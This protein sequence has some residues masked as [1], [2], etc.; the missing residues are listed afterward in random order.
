MKELTDVQKA[1]KPK[2]SLT[3]SIVKID[4]SVSFQDILDEQ[5][6]E[7]ISYEEFRRLADQIEWEHSLDEL[8]QNSH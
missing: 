1:E 7:S 6:Y 4:K 2:L 8:L 3:D 5:D